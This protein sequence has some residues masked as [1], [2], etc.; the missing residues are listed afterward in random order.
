MDRHLCFPEFLTDAGSRLAAEG[1][2][3]LL[4][5][6]LDGEPFAQARYLRNVVLAR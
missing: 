2:G 4:R 1:S 3:V 6:N 5:L